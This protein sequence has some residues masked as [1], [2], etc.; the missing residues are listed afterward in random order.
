MKDSRSSPRL[1]AHTLPHPTTPKPFSMTLMNCSDLTTGLICSPEYCLRSVRHFDYSHIWDSSHAVLT[2]TMCRIYPA[3]F[4][5]HSVRKIIPTKNNI[6]RKLKE[7]IFPSR[8]L[9]KYIYDVETDRHSHTG[10]NG[11]CFSSPEG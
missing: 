3:G 8:I 11:C 6:W 5:R 7:D 9:W 2:M 4:R 10:R 1:L